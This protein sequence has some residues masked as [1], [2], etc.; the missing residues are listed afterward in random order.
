[1]SASPLV[2][3]TTLGNFRNLPAFEQQWLLVHAFS[4]MSLACMHLTGSC[5][6]WMTTCA[7]DARQPI[8]SLAEASQ[9]NKTNWFAAMFMATTVFSSRIGCLQPKAGLK[10]PRWALVLSQLIFLTG[11]SDLGF[12]TYLSSGPWYTLSV[13]R[14]QTG[15]TAS[16]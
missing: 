6:L 7:S 12:A 9:N 14:L 1:M 13:L 16:V 8:L 5:L 11:A 2:Y 4:G 15:F 10:L 3:D